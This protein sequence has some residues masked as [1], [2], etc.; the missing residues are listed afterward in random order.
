M[1]KIN[2]DDRYIRLASRLL[3]LEIFF[4]VAPPVIFNRE[5]NLVEKSL[6]EIGE[7]DIDI[8][9]RHLE[10]EVVKI[11]KG[12]GEDY[13]RPAIYGLAKKYGIDMFSILKNL[14]SPV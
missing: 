6:D 5:L 10:H 11:C 12:R 1:E 9:R 13:I 4:I 7:L 3:R 8:L 2:F 14:Q